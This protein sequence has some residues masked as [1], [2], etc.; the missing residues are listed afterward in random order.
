MSKELLPLFKH[1]LMLFL[2]NENDPISLVVLCPSRLFTP[3][4]HWCIFLTAVDLQLVYFLLL[5][6]R[7]ILIID[8]QMH[9]DFAILYYF[10]VDSPWKFV[11]FRELVADR[12]V[13]DNV[14]QRYHLLIVWKRLL[15]MTNEFGKRTNTVLMGFCFHGES[16][17][18]VKPYILRDSCWYCVFIILFLIEIILFWIFL[19]WSNRFILSE[20]FDELL[21][22]IGFFRIPSAHKC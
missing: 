1:L 15:C 10:I 19:T 7:L 18:K 11:C 9:L 12:N 6:L 4:R 3:F 21:V 5:T 13:F 20:H 17:V 16:S 2:S 8:T 22:C 14:P